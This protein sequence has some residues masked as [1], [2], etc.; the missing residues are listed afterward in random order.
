[1]PFTIHTQRHARP[2][3]A[4]SLLS[5]HHLRGAIS[6]IVVTFFLAALMLHSMTCAGPSTRAQQSAL[7]AKKTDLPSPF[8]L[9]HDSINANNYLG[10]YLELQERAAEYLASPKRQ[11]DYYDYLATMASF[12]GDYEADYQYEEKFLA[13]LEPL[14]HL[15]RSFAH[16]LTSSPIDKAHPRSALTTIASIAAEHQVIMINEEH[17]TPVHRALTRQL[18]SVL[19]AKGFRYF[20]VETLEASDTDLNRRGYPVKKSG[21][22]SVEPVFGDMLRTALRLGYKLV[23]YEYEQPCE[24]KPDNPIACDDERERGQAQNLV[25]RILRN[26]PQA[27][28]LVHVGR[29]HN[30]KEKSE[31]FAFMAWYF[32]E[33]SKLDPFAIDQV[34]MSERRNPAD[35]HALYRYITRK[36]QLTEPTVFQ[37]DDGHFLKEGAYDLTI[38]TPRARYEQGRPTWLRMNG[39]R[40]PYS[41]NFK[42]LKLPVRAQ[43]FDGREPLLLQASLVGE[44][45]DAVPVDQI[46]IYPGRQLPVLLLPKGKVRISAVDR[47]GKAVGQYETTIK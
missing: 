32:K 38:V 22:Y 2:M 27:K 46:I 31:Q 28:I 42:R 35:E 30:A 17:R 25:D 43:Q 15:R 29:G 4:Q 40:Q 12:V 5:R 21:T 37:F 34:D 6:K 24:P 18:L 47:A 41:V 14:T 23:P 9:I 33:I 16:E 3:R 11:R 13:A 36:W 45:A 10:P 44:S 1:M 7:P 26:D 39:L 19:Y 20:A 8:A